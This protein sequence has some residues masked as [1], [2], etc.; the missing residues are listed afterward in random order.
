ML[1]FTGCNAREHYSGWLRPMKTMARLAQ[2]ATI[3]WSRLATMELAMKEPASLECATA[4]TA[5]MARTQ[6]S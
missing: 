2:T 1:G 6:P 4:M 3:Q 5:T